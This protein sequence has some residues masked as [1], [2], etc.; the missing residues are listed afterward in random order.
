MKSIIVFLSLLYCSDCFAQDSTMNQLT[1]DMKTE[2]SNEKKPTKIFESERLINANTT[3]TVGK[4][5]MDFKVTH[6]FDDIVSNSV[7]GRHG[8]VR[9]FFGLDNST[10]IRIGFHVGI[11][12]RLDLSIARAK[13]GGEVAKTR[14]P[15]LFELGL[16]YELMRQLENDPSHPIAMAFFMNNV[17]S[18]VNSSY[19]TPFTVDQFGVRHITDTSLNQPYTFKNLGQRMSQTFQLIIAKKMGKISL[20][21]SPTLVHQGYVPLHDEQ[22]IFAL[23]GA[24]RFPI[25]KNMN[26][27]VDYFHSFRSKESKDYFKSADNTINPPGDIDKNVTPFK[28]YDPLGV[29]LEIITSGHVFH[30][31]F[32]NSTEILENRLIPY[33]VTSWWKGQ[34]RW[35]FNL[36]RTFSLWRPKNK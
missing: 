12:D 24:I 26:I 29:G 15:Q 31:N 21:L 7:Y 33:T 17:I 1:K 14:V 25:S 5:K 23:G 27:I 4:G 6:N 2:S 35:G 32:T 28:F 10:D 36:S 18:T 11:T 30:L 19:P 22:T 34:F 13:G 9:N 8:G 20:Q 3:Q 16:K